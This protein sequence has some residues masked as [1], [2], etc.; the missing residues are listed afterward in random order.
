MSV[1]PYTA[2]PFVAGTPEAEVL[3]QTVLAFAENLRADLIKPLLPKH[4][5]DNIQ[6]DK[7]YPHQSWMNVLKEIQEMPGSSEMFVAFGK[8]V[9]KSAAMPPEMKTIPDALNALH[10]IHHMNLRNI[11]P[12]EGYVVEQKGP[13]HYYVYENTPNPSDAIYGFIWGLCAR[14]KQPGESFSVT[15]RE[16]PNSHQTPGQ[17]FE[18]KWG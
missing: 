18:V 7:W 3:G 10:D 2:K 11:P 16:N 15:P 4:G 17:L 14:F 6:P 13:K 9:V 12:E 1:V 5:L 8:Q